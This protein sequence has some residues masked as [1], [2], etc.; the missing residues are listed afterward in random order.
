M[1]VFGVYLLGPLHC[2]RGL[3]GELLFAGDAVEVGCPLE[4]RGRIAVAGFVEEPAANVVPHVG[5]SH[6]GGGELEC[7]FVQLS[8]FMPAV[9]VLKGLGEYQQQ[10]RPVRG[11]VQ[12]VEAFLQGLVLAVEQRQ[13]P[14]TVYWRAAAGEGILERLRVD[15]H[16][17]ERGRVSAPKD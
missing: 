8:S 17:A 13:K 9:L 5:F 12:E 7:F 1:W 3:L 6:A 14:D 2:Q 16:I 15:C 10:F 11:T 4:L